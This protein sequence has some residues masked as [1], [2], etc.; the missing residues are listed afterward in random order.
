M[1]YSSNVYLVLG[2]WSAI[3]DVNTLIDVGNDSAVLTEILRAPT[4]VGKKA[5]AQVICTHSHFDHTALLPAIRERYAP[6]VYGHPVCACV[7]TPLRDGQ[8][9]RCGDRIFE[10]IFTPGHSEDSVCLYCQTDGVL[11]VGDTPVVI[12]T[13]DGSHEKN[14][15]DALERLAQKDV[16]A[17]YFGH[18]DP[19]LTNANQILRESLSNVRCAIRLHGNGEI[20]ENG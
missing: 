16:R 12:R 17:I 11:F 10:V 18:G 4:G 8:T 13:A 6:T 1:V 9:L 20:S 15:A 5:V 14:F 3:E 2:D 7:E 19:I